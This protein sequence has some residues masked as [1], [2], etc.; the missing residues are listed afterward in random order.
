MRRK[1][2]GSILGGFPWLLVLSTG[3]LL[4]LFIL[5][6]R[7]CAIYRAQKSEKEIE[8]GEQAEIIVYNDDAQSCFKMGLEDYIC[9]VVAAEMPV[10]F[11]MEALKAQAVA[12]RTYALRR[13]SSPCGR[14]GA[15]ICTDSAC[16]QA[17]RSAESMK[18][19]WQSDYK[20][21]HQKLCEA[22][23][24]T[25]GEAIYYDGGLIE[26]LYHS[27]SGGKTEDAQH[28]FAQAQPY[29]VSVESPGEEISEKFSEALSISRRELANK[30]N[31][32]WKNAGLKAARLPKQIEVL[33][34]YDSGR[35]EELRLGGATVSGREMRKL[36]GLNSANF[37]IAY[38]EDAAVFST[39]GYGHG[40]GMSQYGANAMALEGADYKEILKYYYAGVDIK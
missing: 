20:K 30:V 36:L 4:S 17:Y 10:S 33:S 3:I 19:N 14:G 8:S 15:Q 28:V 26:A 18:K 24:S 13:V 34:R 27:S 39:L 5:I 31:R 21:N 37:T 16:C 11:G 40:V 29:L 25:S 2:K 1:R 35:V 22:V 9:G 32:R 7:S 23:F 12:A 38:T 6:F